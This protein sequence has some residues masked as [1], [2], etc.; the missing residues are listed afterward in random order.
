[1]AYFTES[2]VE[3]RKFVT[4]KKGFLFKWVTGAIIP[5]IG[6]SLLI[7]PKESAVCCSK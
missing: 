1:M 2:F 6:N 4:M 3:N 7:V 5:V